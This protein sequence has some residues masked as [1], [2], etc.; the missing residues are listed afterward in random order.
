M[1]SLL[2]NDWKWLTPITLARKQPVPQFVIDRAFAKAAFF[3]PRCNFADR[4]GRL[5][6]INDWRIDRDTITDEYGGIGLLPM[7]HR[8]EADATILR[9][10]YNFADRKIELAREFEIA[11]V[12]R[13]DG[14]NRTRAVAE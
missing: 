10:L 9:W 7:G 2:P 4:V 3:E 1:F 14:L 12:V 11:F 8:L 6:P 13:R 5:Q